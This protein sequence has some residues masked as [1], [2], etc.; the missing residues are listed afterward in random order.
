[1]AVI[2][3]AASGLSIHPEGRSPRPRPV[4]HPH[5][6]P[7][8]QRALASDPNAHLQQKG[9]AVKAV[10]IADA[11]VQFPITVTI[12]EQVTND[13][14][15]KILTG[16]A[17]FSPLPAPLKA[18]KTTVNPNGATVDGTNPTASADANAGVITD[19]MV[20]IS[21]AFGDPTGERKFLS[22]SKPIFATVIGVLSAVVCG[23]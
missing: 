2:A 22:M 13:Y 12:P 5:S 20:S 8:Q 1:P 6:D 16:P 9:Q 15:L 14:L 10:D 21:P 19:L 3:V 11:Y 4:P 7:V 18:L 23:V 17:V